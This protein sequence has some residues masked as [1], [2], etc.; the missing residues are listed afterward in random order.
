VIAA[1]QIPARCWTNGRSTTDRYP[2]GLPPFPAD[3]LLWQNACELGDKALA[4]VL[5]MDET[6]W[7]ATFGDWTCDWSNAMVTGRCG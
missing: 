3:S 1:R 2:D 6:S 5:D 4:A 7:T